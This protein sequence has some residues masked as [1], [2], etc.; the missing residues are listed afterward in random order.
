LTQFTYQGHLNDANAPVNGIMDFQV[1]LWD[2]A[3]A[4]N[5][6]GTTLN[7]ENINVV[8]ACSI[9]RSTL[10]RALLMATRAG[11]SSMSAPM[12]PDDSRRYCLARQ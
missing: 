12:A 9:S 6:I 2:N 10:G 7:I 8:M 5:Q 3:M 11:Y 1:S 4:G